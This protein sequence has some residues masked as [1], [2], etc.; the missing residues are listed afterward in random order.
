M[1]IKRTTNQLM[2][3][4]KKRGASF[5]TNS[6]SSHSVYV[7]ENSKIID[8]MIEPVD[9]KVMVFPKEYGWEWDELSKPMDKLNYL[10]SSYIMNED[11]LEEIAEMVN[12]VTGGTLVINGDG[13]YK[14]GLVDH[15]SYG[16]L[17]NYPIKEVVFSSGYTIYTGNDND[18]APDSFFSRVVGEPKYALLNEKGDTI[19][20][21]HELV[22]YDEIAERYYEVTNDEFKKTIPELLT[23]VAQQLSYEEFE[24]HKIHEQAI[25]Y[26]KTI[27]PKNSLTRILVGEPFVIVM[28]YRLYDKKDGSTTVGLPEHH[29][30][31]VVAKTYT[32]IKL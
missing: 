11:K 1:Y 26:S 8:Q 24:Y 31:G 13:D 23:D 17:G 3:H 20:R 32:L 16:I 12:D 15:Q 4:I 22:K 21:F 9:G 14:W 7:G 18:S 29:P 6:S 28:E 27:E 10:I 19:S 5:E 2:K 25:Y 30:D